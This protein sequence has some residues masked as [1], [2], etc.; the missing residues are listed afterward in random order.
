MAENALIVAE[1]I[2]AQ[3]VFFGDGM[4]AVLSQIRAKID[5]FEGDAETEEGRKEIVS[6]AYK[7]SRS[8]T[9][10]DS[11]RK[12]LIADAKK[13]IEQA[14]GS[15][16][17]A[18]KQLDAWRDEVR[19]PVTD[20]EAEQERIEEKR[21]AV[22]REKVDLLRCINIPDTTEGLN[23]LIYALERTQ[24]LD[25]EYFEFLS[26]AERIH[27]E[28]LTA[29]KA[30]LTARI[31][32]DEEAA[33]QKAEAERLAKEREEQERIKS[34]QE[35][36][37]R[38]IDEANR[39]IDEEKAE[40]RAE[41]E[42]AKERLLKSR[43]EQLKDVVWN[44]HEALDSMDGNLVISYDGLLSCP[45]RCFD[46]F[47]ENRN[48][49]VSKRNAE[50]EALEKAEAE[51][52][53]KEEAQRIERLKPDKEKLEA[54]AQFLEEGIEF[55]EVQSEEANRILTQVEVRLSNIVSALLKTIETI[56]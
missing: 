33:R 11:I 49:K 51:K 45:D 47:V 34:E 19:Q 48:A 23:K 40:I 10:L 46:K 50:R 44:G 54:F 3:K 20:Y 15:W 2:D 22:L 53:A 29:A 5:E 37:Q 8:K 38:K 25:T 52:N 55:P 35:E 42:R 4:D 26:E 12:E 6:M 31:K 16:N 41:K 18:K 24:I 39:K 7:V 1:K 36:A 56:M 28:K 14:N 30:A 32:A 43:L 13:K 21:V 9:F 17:P 27:E